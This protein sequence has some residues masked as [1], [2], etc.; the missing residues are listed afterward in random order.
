[1]APP[2][3]K[4]GPEILLEIFEWLSQDGNATLVPSVL[5]CRKWQP[6]VLSVLY[7]DVVLTQRRLAKFVE[8]STDHKIR[9]LTLRLEAIPVN[10]Y[11]PSEAKQTAESRLEAL[12]RLCLRIAGMKPAAL[13][14]SVDFPFPFTASQEISSI[15]DHLPACCVSLEIDLRYGSS[16]ANFTTDSQAHLHLC[17]SIRA[18]IPRLQHLRLR[19]PLICPAIFS[20]E[21]PSRNAARQVI[22]APMLKTCLINLS[23]RTPGPYSSQ[24][25]WATPCSDDTTRIPYVGQLN[26]LSSA[27]PPFLPALKDFARL[28]STTLERF[29]VIDVES[30]DSTR[31]HSWAAWVRRD[32]ISNTS[33]PIPVANIGHFG[34]D[35]WL[36]RVPSPMSPEKTH[37]WLSSPDV[38]E[39]LAEG[40]TWIETTSGARLPITMLREQQDTREALTRVPFQKRNGI[41]CMLWR[42]EDET[43]EKLLS[44]G[45]GELMQH[46]DLNELT[47]SGWTRDQRIASP[48]VP[49]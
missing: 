19:L 36:A 30:R 13:S 11:D 26:Q 25:V 15:L 10:P 37:D 44:E 2:I 41:S 38:L 12:R 47:P 43:G 3:A 27:L 14:I 6:L 24:G 4:L 49:A 20:A 1:M 21:P 8:R 45:P 29:W 17:D 40:G 34:C 9:S 22:R 48:M 32:F 5:C 23:L 7:G 35:A 46:W 31:P 33:L 28:N 39:T 18:T 16:I 42:N